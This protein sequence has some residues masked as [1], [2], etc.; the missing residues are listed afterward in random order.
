MKAF[1]QRIR[2]KG[3]EKNFVPQKTHSICTWFRK[4]V[5]YTADFDECE[6][7]KNSLNFLY[8]L[9]FGVIF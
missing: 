8:S 6:K 2:N 1:F 9:Q 7:S 3:Q 5:K 4:G